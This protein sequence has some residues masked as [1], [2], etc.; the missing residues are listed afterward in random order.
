MVPLAAAAVLLLIFP[1]GAVGGGTGAIATVPR[2]GAVSFI[3]LII[4]TMTLGVA[5]VARRQSLRM[6]VRHQA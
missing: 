5:F 1:F 6:G 2:A 4:M 3:S